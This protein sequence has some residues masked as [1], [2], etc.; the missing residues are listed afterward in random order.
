MQSKKEAIIQRIMQ[1]LKPTPDIKETTLEEKMREALRRRA[2]DNANVE[3]VADTE[4]VEAEAGES[5]ES[6]RERLKKKKK[7]QLSIEEE[8]E[9][10]VSITPGPLKRLRSSSL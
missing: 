3:D 10:G 9:K 1:S 2:K 5:E 4:V 7:N 8:L 6:L